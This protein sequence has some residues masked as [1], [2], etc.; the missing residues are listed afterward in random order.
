MKWSRRFDVNWLSTSADD[1]RTMMQVTRRFWRLEPVASM[2]GLAVLG[3]E[4]RRSH[5]WP[6]RAAIVVLRLVQ[7]ATGL[8]IG[9]YS[10][11]QALTSA[12]MS[13][14]EILGALASV[15]LLLA[16]MGLTSRTQRR[17]NGR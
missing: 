7:V 3:N 2:A 8:T 15:L 14:G 1:Y 9:Y 6:L 5:S 10:V 11:G 4:E 16:S 17:L 13:Q 12:S